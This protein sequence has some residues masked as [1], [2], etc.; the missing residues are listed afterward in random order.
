M[1]KKAEQEEA[2]K[3]TKA[4]AVRRALAEGIENPTEGS[5]YVK[6]KFGL[7]IA[8]GMFSSYKSQMKAKQAGGGGKEKS[9]GRGGKAGGAG[10]IDGAVEAAGQLRE[11]VREHGYD[12]IKKLLEIFADE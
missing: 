8:P 3:M 2:E 1:A 10:G 11:L 6:S 12:N 5:E 7:D 9:G 4:E